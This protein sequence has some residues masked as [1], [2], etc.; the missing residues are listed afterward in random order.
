MTKNNI[1]PL[2][3]AEF[4]QQYPDHFDRLGEVMHLIDNL[5]YIVDDIKNPKTIARKL[6]EDFFLNADKE[7][8]EHILGLMIGTHLIS[9]TQASQ[10]MLAWGY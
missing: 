9:Q 7:Y 2:S 5:Y 6:N 4:Y 3:N 10:I 1:T 8:R